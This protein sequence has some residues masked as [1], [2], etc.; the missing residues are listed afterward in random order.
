MS[1]DAKTATFKKDKNNNLTEKQCEV[2]IKD[3]KEYK[4]G[5]ILKI[6]NPKTNKSLNDEDR[7]KYIYN[8]CKKKLELDSESPKPKSKSKSPEPEDY[9]IILDSY[10]LD[11][12]IEAHFLKKKLF[13]V[14]LFLL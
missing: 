2:F 10:K 4:N 8:I 13:V 14:L 11:Y 1:T 7:I 3:Y 6:N 12:K 9:E 5:K